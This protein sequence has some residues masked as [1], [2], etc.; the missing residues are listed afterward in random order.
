MTESD[1]D[2]AARRY[3]VGVARRYV[4]AVA[5]F[6]GVALIVALVPSTAPER[7]TS[8]GATDSGPLGDAS[9]ERDAGLTASEGAAGEPGLA[10]SSA[11]GATGA[12]QAAA[13][14]ATGAGQAASG[15]A[16]GARQ[17]AAPGATAGSTT[18]VARSGVLCGP[19]VR[20]V[21]W[22]KYAPPCVAAWS[23]PNG[24]ATA[25]GVTADTITV[26][27]RRS[28]APGTAALS[29][30]AKGTLAPD[31]DFLADLN[32]YLPLFNRDYELY[33]RR[34]V[35]KTFTGRGDWLQ[36]STGQN[37]QGAQ[38]DAATV[39]QM[40]AF[41]DISHF[42]Y[43]TLPYATALAQNKVVALNTISYTQA[44]YEEYDP[45]LYSTFP[46]AD[47]IGQLWANVV[48][49][50]LAG[51]KASFAGSADYK[52]RKRV[53]GI[54]VPDGPNYREVGDIAQALA[55]RDCG[56]TF[57]ER[58]DYAF[59]V[60][61]ATSQTSSLIA[62]MKAAGVTTMVVYAN[63]GYL[64]Q[65]M[66]Q[67]NAQD[68]RP[69]WVI[70][71]AGDPG[72]RLPPADQMAHSIAPSDFYFVS[73]VTKATSEAYRAFKLAQ[74]N[75]EPQSY[76]YALAYYSLLQLFDGLQAAGPNLSPQRFRDGLFGLPPSLPGGDNGTWSFGRGAYSPISSTQLTA[77]DS[78]AVSE[79]DGQRGTSRTCDDGRWY[80]IGSLEGWAPVPRQ[81]ACPGRT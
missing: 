29:A 30:S 44:T 32:A 25:P 79:F 46:T 35:L 21:A 52:Q 10:T 5:F 28:D 17:P 77:W 12:P 50:R 81:P 47:R 43:M 37:L 54:A 57:A 39:R 9:A 64:A 58:V 27:F 72:N 71:N 70:V 13:G 48:C 22:S 78:N 53:F 73:G 26:T 6:V 20:Q 18:D 24:G 11:P 68:Y 61:A 40:G 15:G 19:D 3:V 69:E 34:V 33:G 67:A 55:K 42:V 63:A 36:E 59:D 45:Y 38:A 74:P 7:E 1:I 8:I 76:W 60:V 14:D 62:R 56:Q 2:T 49:A 75:R 65:L 41:A 16:T 23:G 66:Q 31:A 51:Q 4:P 80:P